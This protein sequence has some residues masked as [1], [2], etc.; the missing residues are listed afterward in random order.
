MYV[1][2]YIN[3]VTVRSSIVGSSRSKRH[4]IYM[5]VCVCTYYVCMYV[6]INMGSHLLPSWVQVAPNDTK[7]IY[8]CM[9]VYVLR[10]YVRTFFHSRFKSALTRNIYV[11]ACV[12]TTYVCMYVY[13]HGYAPSSIVGSSPARQR[14]SATSDSELHS[15]KMTTSQTHHV[16]LRA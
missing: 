12:R 16:H 13:K 9:R 8:I 6:C 10:M 11:H 4:E 2:M 14:E 1:C 7:Y 5:F 3:T 15:A